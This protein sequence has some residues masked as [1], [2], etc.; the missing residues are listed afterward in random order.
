MTH[1][2]QEQTSKWKPSLNKTRWLASRIKTAILKILKQQIEDV[3]KVKKRSKN[4]IEMLIMGQDKR[5]VL[6]STME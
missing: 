3:K 2:K 6:Q 4:K 1:L 5:E